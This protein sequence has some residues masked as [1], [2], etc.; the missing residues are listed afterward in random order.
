MAAIGAVH[1]GDSRKLHLLNSAYIT[2]IPKKEEPISIG[3]YW[4]I[5][6]IHSFGKLITKIMAN[7]LAPHLGS[8]VAT[9]Q[10]AFIRGRRIHDNFLL[11]QQ[12]AKFLHNKGA[13]RILIKLD[14]SK[15]FN[16]ISWPFILEILSHRGFGLKWRALICN[17]FSSSSTR[18]LL[19]GEPGE[20]IRHRRGLRQGDPLSTMLFIMAMDVLSGLVT[21]ADE[22]GLLQP[23][24]SRNIGHRLFL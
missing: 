4:P 1:G 15:A 12:M 16:S 14:I 21:K 19:N 22:L 2:L 20:V 13:S 17:L 7:R 3:D 24:A 9:N 6:L 8:M 5:S 11:V 10:S 18:V 23:L